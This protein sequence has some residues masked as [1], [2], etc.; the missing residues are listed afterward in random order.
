MYGVYMWGVLRL[1]EHYELLLTVDGYIVDI[2]W[3]F[4]LTLHLFRSTIII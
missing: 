2:C 1:G 4:S 3:F